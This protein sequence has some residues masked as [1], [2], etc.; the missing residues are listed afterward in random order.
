MQCQDRGTRGAVLQAC[1]RGIEKS[2]RPQASMEMG[3]SL[4]EGKRVL[5]ID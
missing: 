5:P 1:E 3:G 4:S 2:L